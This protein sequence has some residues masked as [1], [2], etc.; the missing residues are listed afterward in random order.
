MTPDTPFSQDF[1]ERMQTLGLPVAA[2]PFE[3]FPR[4]VSNASQMAA[5]VGLL[6][7]QASMTELVRRTL[8]LEKLMVAGNYNA[9]AYTAG[10]IS[11]LAFASGQV[12]AGGSPMGDLFRFTFQHRLQ[13][14][15]WQLVFM[16]NRALTDP[17]SQIPHAFGNRARQVA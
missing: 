10:V 6:E 4:A 1:S 2:E 8:G 11:C 14:P 13:F 5:V 9:R 15:G 16:M 7:D 17:A 3:H 12:R